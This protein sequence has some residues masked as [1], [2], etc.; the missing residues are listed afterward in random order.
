MNKVFKSNGSY[1]LKFRIPQ[2]IY[3]TLISSVINILLKL[4]SLT[5]QNILKL[6]NAKKFIQTMKIS[7]NIKSHICIKHFVFF[8][9]S[10]FLLL[11]F[12]YFI[13]CFCGVYINT[14]LILI[15]DSFISF[16]LSMIYPFPYNIIPGIFRI[17]AL[18]APKK[19]K[20]CK[21][22]FSGILALI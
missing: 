9:L 1:N 22:Q 14:Q 10:A 6:K 8:I 2:L 21:Y 5:E 19:D 17:S 12:W 7:K 11:F 15:K 13:T 20:R 4:L 16:G 18:R 3:S